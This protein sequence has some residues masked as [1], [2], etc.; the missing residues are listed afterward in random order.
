MAITEPAANPTVAVTDWV[1]MAAAQLDAEKR[2]V[3]AVGMTS[4]EGADV[5]VVVRFYRVCIRQL[6]GGNEVQRRSTGSQ[7]HKTRSIALERPFHRELLDHFRRSVE[8]RDG[9]RD[10]F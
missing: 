4:A 2:M 3:F 9:H 5:R 6:L 1:N 10:A 8:L 7:F